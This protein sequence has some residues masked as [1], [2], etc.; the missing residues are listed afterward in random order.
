MPNQPKTA[1]RNIRIP[2]D[3]WQRALA[4]ARARNETLSGVLRRALERYVKRHGGDA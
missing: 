1:G 4:I 2:D 3:L